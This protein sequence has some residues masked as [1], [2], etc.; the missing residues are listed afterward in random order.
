MHEGEVEGEHRAGGQHLPERVRVERPA[1]RVAVAHYGGQAGEVDSQLPVS[2]WMT[3][4]PASRPSPQTIAQI[5]R[6]SGV[7]ES[8]SSI[9][10]ATTAVKLARSM[11][12]AAAR[13]G[14]RRIVA[15]T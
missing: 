3:A 2:C 12:S 7:G 13:R 14:P 1:L 5:A 4:K 11:I 15:I 6:R 9:R 8:S 10:T